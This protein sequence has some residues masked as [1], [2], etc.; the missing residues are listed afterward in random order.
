MSQSLVRTARPRLT[1]AAAEAFERKLNNLALSGDGWLVVLRAIAQ[2]T[3]RPARLVGVHGGVLAATDDGTTAM[4]PVSVAQVFAQDGCVTITCEPGWHGTA[5]AVRAGERRVGLLL[6]GGAEGQANQDD[7]LILRAAS[8]AIAIEAIRRDAV[9]AASTETAGRLIDELRFGALRNHA[10][11][12]RTAAR[13]GLRLDRPHA[14]V[15]FAYGGP[16]QR[17]W[18]TALSWLE[19]PVRQDGQFGLAVLEG[20]IDREISRIRVRLQG[21]VGEEMVLAAAGPVVSDVRETS[22]SFRD[23]ETVLGLLRRRP[24]EVELKFS[25]LGLAQLLFGVSPERLQA[26]V[27]QHLGPILEREE[28]VNT[29]SAW[30]ATKGSRAAVAELLHLHRNSVGYRVGQI[31]ELLDANPLDPEVTLR[32]Q[33][34]LT[35]RELLSVL[36]EDKTSRR[37]NGSAPLYPS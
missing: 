37:G 26:F 11:V 5:R 22:R 4:T 2:Q 9:A 27:E 13:F 23:A 36:G 30:L 31:R 10:E 21:M 7:D 16:N 6:L 18:S 3:G 25:S 19:M 1:P 8:T 32:L 14:A 24:G 28:W 20:D 12:L 29:L 35:A 34:A 17:T 33:A 15:V